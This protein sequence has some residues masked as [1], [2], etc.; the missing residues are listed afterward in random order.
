MSSKITKIHSENNIRCEK[1]TEI[2][3]RK[4]LEFLFRKEL[5]KQKN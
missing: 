1:T 4:T 2:K 3:N 5:E